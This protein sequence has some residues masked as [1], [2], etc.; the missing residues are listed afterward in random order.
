[1]KKSSVKR[2]LS[3]AMALTMAAQA[4]PYAGFVA[5]AAVS[6]SIVKKL[7]DT[8]YNGNLDTA[9]AKLEALQRAGIIDENGNMV[10]LDIREGGT[11]VTLADAVT[12][13]NAGETVGDITVNGHACSHSQLAQIYQVKTMLDMLQLM[14]GDVTITPEH[15]ANLESLITG[16]SDGSIDLG[17]LIEGES[18]VSLTRGGALRGSSTPEGVPDTYVSSGN[19]SAADGR[20]V[21]PFISDDTYEAAHSF[22]LIDDSNT[23]YY[24]D[25]KTNGVVSDGII[26]LSCAD[27]VSSSGTVT[28]TATL[29][30]AQALPVSF[31]WSA[32]G[33]S[34]NVSGS[35]TIT[36][37]ANT[38]DSKTFEVTVPNR[39]DSDLW[40]GSRAFVINVGN[41]KN[42][43]IDDDDDATNEVVDSKTA[44]S[45][46]VSV[47]ANDKS[48]ILNN[49]IV[50]TT[51]FNN[52][53]QPNSG[54]SSYIGGQVS[55]LDVGSNITIYL[56]ANYPLATYL[57]SG[58]EVELHITKTNDPKSSDRKTILCGK[59]IGSSDA[60]TIT[61]TIMVDDSWSSYLTNGTCY[62]WGYMYLE[63]RRNN[64]FD[65][66]T[67]TKYETPTNV[68][69]NNIS[70]PAGTYHSGQVVPIT[71]TLNDYALANANTKLK[72]NNV[73]CPLIDSNGLI[74]KTFTF[75]YTVKDVDT[76]TINV[77]AL[78]GLLN[79]GGKA[80]TITNSGSM[81]QSFGVDQNVKL[82][83]KIKENSID[84]ANIKY[85]IDD[86]DP[87]EQTATIMIPLKT[88]AD[89]TWIGSE[90]VACTNNE[91]GISMKLP[92]Y[93]EVTV[94]DYL[95]GAYFSF[96][97]GKTRYP[98]Y[99]VRTGDAETPVALAARF[100]V[101]ENAT[102]Y[103]R[104]DTVN[105]FMDMTVNPTTNYLG[106]WD[107]KQPDAKGYAY[108]D[109]TNKTAA[110]IFVGANYPYYAKGGVFF[111]ADE[112][113]D[114]EGNYTTESD[115]VA[116]GWLKTGD[117]SYVLLQDTEYPDDQYD[118]EIVA[119]KAFHDSA[120]EGLRVEDNKELILSYQFSD[121]KN[122]TFTDPSYFT[123]TSSDETVATVVKDETTPTVA[124]IIMTGK[125]GPVSFTLK[126]GNGTS[127]KEFTLSAGTLNVLE[128]KTPFLNISKYSQNRITL[129]GT[130]TDIQFASN[131]TARNAQAGTAETVFTAKLRKKD[132]EEVLWTAPFTSTLDKP[133][134]H[135]TV[136][137][138]K[139]T[140][141]DE[142]TV[143]ISATYDGGDVNGASTPKAELSATANLT[144]KQKPATIK[145]NKLNSYYVTA[146]SIPEIGYTVSNPEAQVEYTI[147]KSGEEVGERTAVTSGVIPFVPDEPASLKEA[148]VITVYARNTENDAWS[149]DS[150][151]L[152]VY[153][154][155]ILEQ[156]VADVTAGKIG[157][158]TGGTGDD[159]ENTTVVMDNHDKVERYCTIEDK[160]Y[161]LTF[162]DFT[163][164]RTDMSL[165]KIVSLN[166]GE[167]VY[168]MLSDKMEWESSNPS[169]VSVDYKQGG[170]YSD[171][172]NYSYTSY[173][174]ATDFLIVGKD[175][176]GEDKVTITATHAN[177]GIKS[178]FDVKTKT[179][180]DQLYV[181]QFNPAVKTQITYTNGKD[182][183]RELETNDKGELAV[184]EPDGIK[185]AVMALAEKDGKTYVG[186]LY[187]SDLVSGERDIASLQLY[188]SNNLR[189]RV[190]SNADLT[191]IKP[192][193]TAY[194]G[195]VTL[196]GG[197]YKNG[198]YC[199]DALIRVGSSSVQAHS[200][201]T[202]ITANVTDGKLNITFDPTQFKTSENDAPFGAKP[203]DKITYVFEYS[204][205]STYRPGIVTL[206]AST[207]VDGASSP[208]D[209]L[210]QMRNKTGSETHPQIISQ[211]LQQYYGNTATEYSRNVIDYTE[212]VGV[213][214]RFNK[215]VL[216]TEA[217]L[218]NEEVK[219]DV[220]NRY[221][222]FNSENA[223]TDFA[224]YTGNSVKL[225]GQKGNSKK[226][227]D[228]V[229]ELSALE[230]STLFVYPFSTFP[231]ER[232]VY[233]MND[234]NLSR[235][236]I[237]DSG[238]T[239]N[240]YSSI[241]AVFVRDGVTVK[242]E[243]LPFGVSNL[244]HQKDLSASDG[245]TREIGEDI[246]N[247]L[248]SQMSIGSV[249]NSIDDSMLQSG[250]TF[251]SNLKTT[252]GNNPT[253]MMIMPTEDPGK[254]RIIAF[255]GA[256]KEKAQQSDGVS[257]NYDPKQMYDDSQAFD[258]AVK[259]MEDE[260][261][262]K[263]KKKDD[264]N[265]E[266]SIEVNF[267]GAVVLEARI[268][269]LGGD[270][271]I[272]IIGGTAGT[273]FEAKYEYNQNFMCGPVPCN[274]SFEVTADADLEVS[275]ANKESTRALLIDAA[276]G[277]SIEAF[278]GLGF[279]LSL[280]EFK[281][282]IFGKVGARDNFLYLTSGNKTGN[283]LDISGEIGL[284][285]EAKVLCVSYEKIFCSTGF[286]WTKTWDEYENIKK[287]WEEQGF[288]ELT[289][290]TTSGRM[291]TMR[292]M[293]NG[294]A[295]VDIEGG[296]EIE[297]RDYLQN[298]SYTPKM[299]MLRGV[300]DGTLKR[301]AY[302]Y[303]NP[304]L[305][306][307]GG[308]MLYISDN[309]NA[310]SPE[311]VVCYAVKSEDGYTMNDEN[312]KD[313]RV[314]TSEDNILADSGLVV[315][316]TS[317]RA[318]AAWVKQMD[319]PEKEMKDKVTYDDLGIMLN[320]TEIYGS[321]YNGTKW[322]TVRLTDNSVG[323]MSPTVAS[324]DNKAIVAWRSLSATAMPEN[325]EE[326]TQDLSAMFNAENSIN[327]RIFDGA[328]WKKAK[329]AYNGAAGTVNAIDSAMLPDGT[330]ILVYTVRTGEDVKST[331]TFYTVI[332]T[333]GEVLTTGRLTND[334]FTD[335][336]A[337]VTTVGNKF[338]I[339]W[340]SEHE[341]GEESDSDETVVSH[342]IG[343]ARINANGSLDAS[344]PESI[345]G[346]AAS[347]IGSDFHF[348]APANNDDLSK[349]SIVWSQKKDSDSAVDAGKYQLNA[350]R[351]YENNGAIGVTAPAMIAET[352]KNYT[353]DN[354][355]TYTDADGKI[356]AVI[357]G[358]DYSNLDLAVYDT[359]DLTNLA[360]IETVNGE[361]QTSN[362][363]TVFDNKPTASIKLMSGSFKNVAIEASAETDIYELMPGFDQ[364]VQFTVTNTGASVIDT[365]TAQI[366]T[367]A[368][369]T[370]DGLGLLPGQSTVLIYNYSVPDSISD[371]TYTLTAENSETVTGTII[372]N[373]PD[374]GI[375]SM[376]ITRESEKTRD[377][378]LILNNASDIP[379]VGSGKTVK[380]EFYKDSNHQT[381]IGQ[382]III[383]ETAYQ[384]IDNDVYTYTQSLN[385]TD[386]ISES[387]KEIP[388]DGIRVYARAWIDD[389]D[390]LYTLNNNASVSFRG[391]LD[392]YQV[393][394]T[395]DVA[396]ES[397][398]NDTYNVIADIRNN[399]LQ[400][401]DVGTLTA[402]ILDSKHRVLASVPL[403]TG[404][405]GLTMTGEQS[406]SYNVTNQQFSG[407][408]TMVS[409]RSSAKSVILDAGEGT[410]DAVA[411]SLNNDNKIVGNMPTAS[412]GGYVFNGWYTKS[413]GG[414]KV[415]SDTVLEG[416]STIYAQYSYI[417]SSQNWKL[418][419][420]SYE[421][422]GTAHKPVIEGTMIGDVT[423]SYYNADTN[424][425]LSEAP[426]EIGNYIIE[427]YANGGS[428][429]YSLRQSD[430]YS[431]T[432]PTTY[433]VTVKNGTVN[434][435]TSGEFAPGTVIAVKSDKPKNG[436]QFGYWKR[437]GKTAS[438]NSTYTFP[439]TSDDIVLE[440]VYLAADDEFTPNGKCDQDGIVID[441]S[442]R[443]I[444]FAF[445]NNV[446]DNC[447]IVKGG[448]VATCDINKLDSL[449]VGI[450]SNAEKTTFEKVFKT[451]KHTYR[452]RW[453]KTAVDDGQA[454]YVKGYLIYKDAQGVEHTV[455]SD[456]QKA[457]LNGWETIHDDKIVG[458]AFMDTVTC[459]KNTDSSK[460]NCIDFSAL[461][462]V[463]ADC[464]IKFAGVVATSDAS[465]KD[466][467][468]K[469]TE[470]KKTMVNGCYVRGIESTKHT[471]T[472]RWTKTK[473]GNET[474]Y[475]MPY[476]VYTDPLGREQ[477]V[478]G[479]LTTAKFN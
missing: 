438:Y 389:T 311:S 411:L 368:S 187:T 20:Y 269:V 329:I 342:D 162:E 460:G 274:V 277:V 302:P 376:K 260:K 409:L 99:V 392:K 251:L 47:Y 157:G 256:K 188:P 89:L 244:S 113:V 19:I 228:Q 249:F 372:L 449:K 130:D 232:S 100:A 204:F 406:I 416:G 345:G 92:T 325:K 177:T 418:T 296:N 279:D 30:K 381:K 413:S 384:D 5:G 268:G 327:Y 85:G 253:N 118:V 339:G 283:K 474:W 27:T 258:K 450:G 26:T 112:T 9:R 136:P 86:K 363:L 335:T 4:V 98:V 75:G 276:I 164:L 66:F 165:Q 230:E 210:V 337:Q 308:L 314:D 477:F 364:P 227:A 28:V 380:L 245:G 313:F 114:R 366:G 393:P 6:E 427:V 115:D 120:V 357:L 407:T 144:V 365:I 306:D 78:T 408:P 77:T 55:G 175:D 36:W 61:K 352:A 264:D 419:M 466:Y 63:D 219:T 24:T 317:Q 97:N 429:H 96:D 448:V 184:Y 428:T 67:I 452:Y 134:S 359:I 90:S 32:A 382:T 180:K 209:S 233:T 386:F 7:A 117:N 60:K 471:V 87:C 349:L 375:G 122:F 183:V 322:E 462:N 142:Y 205:G 422:D 171:I 243:T 426:T 58:E 143:E 344:F 181:F 80:V 454:W 312:G 154:P 93:G 145:L 346:T 403:T 12:R 189:L 298:S 402:D 360:P 340:Y 433:T 478:Y 404:E 424:E 1:M 169:T 343:L 125:T 248:K 218:L 35:G 347:S 88:D 319:S 214:A 281:L 215:A 197:V 282:G 394:L 8:A 48:T 240:P 83:S 49:Y 221:A 73:D 17:T 271:G 239:P 405:N 207:D 74:S 170:I 133:I 103:L 199:P 59:G 297:N 182:E 21:Q 292:L 320:A 132:S 81:A 176:T 278:A 138:T 295:L 16:L 285:M 106:T 263:K 84:F 350:V 412:R 236:G 455:Y 126:V 15:T 45:K 391:L 10:N 3:L 52:G 192:D 43:K 385:V 273:N 434:G 102:A 289:G 373:R 211:T 255:V 65:S 401:T 107:N 377:V 286:N 178:S 475:V 275:F 31:D 37:A 435:E 395:M 284:K 82:V 470:T 105:F 400:D 128:G 287:A 237:T 150:M 110:P 68:T 190:I 153:N 262:N 361:G 62:I 33:A 266:A 370:F 439:V 307:D 2:A 186:T 225:T 464:K 234:T 374:V 53:T 294:N 336:N 367:Q 220:N 270:W 191:F 310:E 390:E 333:D 23:T 129:T 29:N 41:V 383:P 116:H 111:T 172:R 453:T 446:P 95:K 64:T 231:I 194:T 362:H 108:F 356:N 431:I 156:I 254:F 338:I 247:N 121:R 217:A 358:S 57:A 430:Y 196:R 447:T 472:Y 293:S 301:F 11:A 51:S 71:V 91:V 25:S 291:F 195:E 76:G 444:E 436:Y 303:A 369:K 198:V 300:S 123:W 257:V 109:G 127:T 94:R 328:Q 371:V 166:Y 265:G 463:P 241:K 443:T 290:R 226:T 457:T 229:I 34:L 351:F 40:A 104:Q 140:A 355:D 331:E 305:T 341:A 441:K 467:L 469:I 456:L 252:G 458:T 179:L 315:S 155:N 321:S 119:N 442:G 79:T 148:Y 476:L 334:G 420:E 208:T 398:E 212:N 56:H 213:S 353:I 159:V 326:N 46:T 201:R 421:Y 13:I 299:T 324:S 42:A 399:S 141:K 167:Q 272:D 222:S 223:V 250:F 72:V 259:E 69:I 432:E 14:D 203:G 238:N 323:D 440:A 147:Q 44:W 396:L 354:Y 18:T 318:F 445:L 332:G 151:L 160:P 468:T 280:F 423:Y 54:R 174:P 22:A 410:C 459:Y 425:L 397:G 200:G 387:D 185:G 246:N 417:Y 131:L 451:N 161:Q 437:N 50:G 379:L 124:H 39:S 216:T 414:E 173:T 309:N 348:S 193:G 330:S 415:T 149:V 70:V 261:K 137:G 461:L 388:D 304:V 378:Q 38:T 202:D 163:T 242:S 473:V 168:G 152:N 316:G 101:P 206:N 158:T 139:L 267:Y 465:K 288:A 235:D 135:I 146:G 224:M 479:D